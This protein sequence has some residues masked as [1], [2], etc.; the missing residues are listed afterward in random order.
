MIINKLEYNFSLEISQTHKIMLDEAIN[1][2][3]TMNEQIFSFKQKVSV[4][5]IL[6]I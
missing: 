3:N 5:N 6:Y 4:Y 1:L 2:S